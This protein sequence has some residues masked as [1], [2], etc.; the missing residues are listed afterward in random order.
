MLKKGPSG[1]LL[2]RVHREFRHLMDTKI[3]HVEASPGLDGPLLS[4]LRKICAIHPVL[5][6]SQSNQQ[7]YLSDGSSTLHYP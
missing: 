5:T 1:H 3:A 7:K 4:V 2:V 6:L